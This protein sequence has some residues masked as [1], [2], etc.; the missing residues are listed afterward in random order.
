MP[1]GSLKITAEVKGLRDLRKKLRDDPVYA[2]PL[3]EALSRAAAY[4]KEQLRRDAPGSIGQ[5]TIMTVDQRPIPKFAMIVMRYAAKRSKK[6]PFRY[7]WAL[8]NSAKLKS[9]A[10]YHYRVGPHSGQLT[11]H[12]LTNIRKRTADYITQTIQRAAAQIERRWQT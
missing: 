3:R 9:G 4:F 7:P 8:D 12:W 6:G 2:E 1:R 11:Y 10:R 5:R